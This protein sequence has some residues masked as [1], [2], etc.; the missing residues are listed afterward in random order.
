MAPYH[1]KLLQEPAEIARLAELLAVERARSY[2][3]IGAK[4]GGSLWMV[5]TALPAGSRIVAVD[6]PNGTREWSASQRSLH[7]CVEDLKRNGYDAHLI[8]GDST[9][10]GIIQ[11]VYAL[12]PFDAVFI[13]ANHT[14]PYVEK[15]WANYGLLAHIVAFHD[16]AW[17]RAADW[18]GTRIDVPEFWQAVKD[19]YRHEEIKLCPTGKNNGIGVLW[20]W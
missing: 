18:I 16:I 14:R 13:D 10:V 20:R 6:L 8:L 3:E 12:G 11:Q 5:A 17:R 15:D 4:Y 2:L 7:S 9:Q 1:T 19:Q